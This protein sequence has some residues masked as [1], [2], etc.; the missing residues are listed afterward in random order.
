[1]QT[2]LYQYY[3]TADCGVTGCVDWEDESS[4]VCFTNNQDSGVIEMCMDALAIP[5]LVFFGRR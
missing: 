1:M 3:I 5:Q 2:R 4:C